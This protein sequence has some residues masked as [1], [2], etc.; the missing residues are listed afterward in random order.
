MFKKQDFDKGGAE[1]IIGSS[2][3]I[4]GDFVGQGNVVVEGVVTG[5]IKT[6]QNLMVGPKA[7]VLANVKAKNALISGEIR[8]NISAKESL[9]LNS[10]ARVEGDIQTGQLTIATGALFN[11][12]C[13]MKEKGAASR[14]TEEPAEEVSQ[15]EAAKA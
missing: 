14:A 15:E 1:T 8:G 6:D 9:E 11:G 4:E 13:T 7:Q 2:V 3:K 10:T 5:N 12:K